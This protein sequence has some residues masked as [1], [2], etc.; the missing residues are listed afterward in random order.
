MKSILK[1]KRGDISSPI[2]VILVTVA[3]LA[4]AGMTV[5]WMASTGASSATT[6]ALVV[7]GSPMV[8]SNNLMITIKNLGSSQAILQNASIT[9]NNVIYFASSIVP[10]AINSG[11]S[12]AILIT[13]TGSPSPQ[14]GQIYYGSLMTNHGTLAFTA[15]GQ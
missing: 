9:I 3:A 6:G 15:I 2:I 7:I 12:R 13:L 5:A 8:S 4:V 11:E 10:N 1:N 14:S